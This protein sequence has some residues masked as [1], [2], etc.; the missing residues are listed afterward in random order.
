MACLPLCCYT[1][2]IKNAFSNTDALESST[3]TPQSS[4]LSKSKTNKDENTTMKILHIDETFHPNF[5]Y[6]CNPLAKFQSKAGHEVYII[7][8]EAKFIY[9]SYHKFGEYGET[10]D[11]DDRVYEQATGVRIV[12]VP[13]IRYIAGRLIYNKKALYRAIEKIDPEVMLV[14]CVET[15]TAMRVMRKY[16]K[17]YPMA[18][19]SH[20]LSMATK[21]KFHKLY[22]FAYKALITSFIKKKQYKVIKTQNDDYI[23]S[24]LGVPEKQTRFISF[25][26]DTVLFAPDSEVRTAFL[27][28]HGL[29]E[30]TFVITST[31][32]LS[33]EKDGKLFAKGVREKFKGDRP[34]AVVVVACFGGNYEKEVKA[35]LD[36]SE[37]HVFY[38]PIQK[39]LDL[40]KFYQIADVTV[41]PKQCSM[42]FYDA[43]SCAC[44][45]IS[46][47]G[48]VNEDR[49]SHGNGLCFERGS[50]EDFRRQ[51]QT[52]IDLPEEEYKQMQANSLEFITKNYSYDQ[53]AQRYTDVLVEAIDN[54]NKKRKRKQ[55]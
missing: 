38:Y 39:Y 1:T 15:V 11:K 41:F 26:T 30:K 44:P 46:E 29:P 20:M 33:E 42:S 40:P 36:Q 12:R 5:G 25:G 52:L 21:N 45:V 3:L 17:K 43:Q 55:A 54:F 6:Q 50:S 14:H 49:N 23:T 13:G 27:R 18:F 4:I 32:K 8:P 10:L 19:D 51:I 37:N 47:K 34:V 31:G 28:E 7:A 48:R 53:I 16:H 2:G 22:E 35:M 9:P 24:H